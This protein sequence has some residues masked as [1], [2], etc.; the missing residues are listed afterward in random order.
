M[1]TGGNSGIGEATARRFAQEGAKVAILARREAEGR[2]VQDAIRIQ[3]GGIT[4]F[5]CDVTDRAAVEAAVA[6]TVSTYGG[7]DVLINNAGGGAREMFPAESD[8]TWDR[9]LRVNLTACF[10]TCR[11]AWP[12]LIKSGSGAIVNVSSLA[13]VSGASEAVL[14]KFPT[15]PSASYYAA[16]AGLEGFTRYLASLGGPHG[17]RVNCVRPGQILTRRL[18]TGAGEHVFA[19][20]FEIWQLLKGPGY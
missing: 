3:G 8:E 2:A 13:A 4:F 9:V 7:L 18:T 1:I 14:E 6:Q 17:L 10:L 15:L 19:R 20:H 16:K 12:H 11:A 5:P